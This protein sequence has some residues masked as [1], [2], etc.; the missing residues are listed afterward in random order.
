MAAGRGGA[1][2]AAL[3]CTALL[4]PAGFL[5]CGGQGVETY[6]SGAESA[7]EAQGLPQA[8]GLPLAAS[9]VPQLESLIFVHCAVG[10]EPGCA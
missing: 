9:G 2:P 4:W 8:G 5:R 3:A 1:H 7:P 10:A 6:T